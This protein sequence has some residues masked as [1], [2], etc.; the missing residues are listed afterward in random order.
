MLAVEARLLVSPA[1]S[2][3]SGESRKRHKTG[4]IEERVPAGGVVWPV[5]VE[6]LDARGSRGSG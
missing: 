1:R 4:L 2:N 6:Q 3:A 5:Q